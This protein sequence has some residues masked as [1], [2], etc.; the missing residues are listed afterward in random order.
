MITTQNNEHLV[1]F[2]VFGE[3]TLADF[4]EFEELVLHEIKFS[5]PVNLL[6]DLRDMAD[7]TVDVAWE[8]IRFSRQHAGDFKRIAV[9]TDSQWVAWSAW[10]EQ[11]FVNADLTVFA[12]EA[13]A[14]RWLAEGEA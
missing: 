4:K 7:F 14:R 10:L 8:E 2:A 6:V 9:V 3:F 5:G 1:E 12:D 11:L 13:E